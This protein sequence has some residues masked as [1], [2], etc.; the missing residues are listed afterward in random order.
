MIKKV[1]D[2]G[3][4]KGAPEKSDLWINTKYV[5]WLTD[6]YAYVT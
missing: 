5:P 2:W 4:I 1:L 6:E 3:N